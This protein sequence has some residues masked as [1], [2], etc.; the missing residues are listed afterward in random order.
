MSTATTTYGPALVSEI[1]AAPRTTAAGRRGLRTRLGHE[2]T[3]RR[4]ARR[5]ES[6]LRRADHSEAHDLMAAGRRG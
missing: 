3:V 1:P 5:F 6:A 2:L 4:D